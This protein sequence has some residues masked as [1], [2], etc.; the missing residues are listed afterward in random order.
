MVR[1][2]ADHAA[3][4]SSMT[5]TVSD[6]VLSP[7]TVSSSTVSDGT[8]RSRAVAAT[9]T[10]VAGLGANRADLTSWCADLRNAGATELRFYHAGLAST[11]DLAAVREAV[12]A[13]E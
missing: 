4:Q 13:L 9:V 7:D 2:Y 12:A 10:A 8:S 11:A 6:T 5:M 1:A 3:E